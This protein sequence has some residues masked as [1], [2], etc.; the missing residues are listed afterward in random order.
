MS[1]KSNKHFSLFAPECY[2]HSLSLKFYPCLFPYLLQNLLS[3]C[4]THSIILIIIKSN[5]IFIVLKF[6]T[7]TSRTSY[8]LSKICYQNYPHYHSIQLLRLGVVIDLSL[9]LFHYLE[10]DCFELLPILASLQRYV[11][12]INEIHL[13]PTSKNLIP[14]SSTF[15][16]LFYCI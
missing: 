5:A 6:F 15:D 1:F 9:L 2:F 14:S 16:H 12:K 4:I 11:I 7:S 10:I 3:S 13:K 8:H